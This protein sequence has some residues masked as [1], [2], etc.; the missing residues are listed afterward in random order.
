LPRLD[1]TSPDLT[2]F[3]TFILNSR[4]KNRK[5]LIASNF[6][7]PSQLQDLIP[8]SSIE[9]MAVPFLT[10][11]ETV[12]VLRSYKASDSN[13]DEF[14][15]L[16]H[17]ISHGHPTITSAISKFLRSANWKINSEELTRLFKDDY[18]LDLT[19]ET[20]LNVV[21]TI[22]DSETRELLYRL[23]IIRK[24]FTNAQVNLVAQI[25]PPITSPMEKFNSIIGLWVQ[26]AS[27]EKYELSPLIERLKGENLN[28]IVKRRIN[29]SLGLEILSKKKLNQFE[30]QQTIRYFIEGGAV[31]Q[32][33]F[34]LI[35]ALNDALKTPEIF[36]DWG[37]SLYWTYEELPKDMDVSTKIYIRMLHLML[38]IK[39]EGKYSDRIIFIRN[40]LDK[41][42]L[43]ADPSTVNYAYAS[44]FLSTL[45][46]KDDSS[47]S[48]KHF[49][50]GVQFF[51]S[52]VQSPLKGELEKKFNPEQLIWVSTRAINTEQQVNEWFEAFEAL[53]PDRRAKALEL[54]E[55]R[56]GATFITENLINAEEKKESSS[57]DWNKLLSVFE[58]IKIRA[59]EFGI[60]LLLARAFK[61]IIYIH[62][63]KLDDISKANEIGDAALKIFPED[64]RAARFLISD[65]VG[66][67]LFYKG[68]SEEAKKYVAEAIAMEV[69]DFYTDKLDTFLVMSQLLGDKDKV[70]AHHYIQKA[71]EFVK[72]EFVF[73]DTQRVKVRAEFAISLAFLDR[74]DDAI[75]QMEI[76]YDTIF[77][78]GSDLPD[79]KILT[80]R[81]LHVINYWDSIH[82]RKKQPDD[83]DGEPYE[84]PYRGYFF[85]GYTDDYV[86]KNWMDERPFIGT[87]ALL[88]CFE[89]MGDIAMAKKW[90]LS[91][92]A[93]NK[94][95]TN[96]AFGHIVQLAVPYFVLDDKYDEAVECQV[97]VLKQY[98]TIGE[99]L[100]NIQNERLKKAFQNAPIPR[101]TVDEYDWHII[102]AVIIPTTLRLLRLR[103][104]KHPDTNRLLQNAIA[105]AERWKTIFTHQDSIEKIIEMLK[106]FENNRT[107]GRVLAADLQSYTGSSIDPVKTVGFLIASI[108]TETQ[109]SF[110][111]QAA[112]I[113]SLDETVK[114]IS[115]GSYKF[116]LLPF[117]EAF[118]FSRINEQPGDITNVSFWTQ[119][120]IPYYQNAAEDKKTRMMFRILGNHVKGITVT[121]EL[122]NWIDS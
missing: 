25:D 102:S 79:F 68:K 117:L 58:S 86:E 119:K 35:V 10:E 37:F 26:R 111:L 87:Q 19:E 8:E 72:D 96:N 99:T 42:L 83:I 73:S 18:S 112:L 53:S 22:E 34:V 76:G 30:A 107:D 63:A 67:Q 64:E 31:N 32:A 120:S 16:V 9:Y 4:E 43:S 93:I 78:K 95:M 109:Q 17:A 98:N 65:I 47:K 75:Y 14:K 106:D 55:V 27:D 45:Y 90:A 92:V 15:S 21:K 69:D 13:C 12:E 57:Q 2:R 5:L 116:L 70:S 84:A 80:L 28:S 85:R 74:I 6:N 88:F 33:G 61:S 50:S 23:N 36:F 52:S 59:R 103:I 110:Y 104:E 118:W 48:L 66:R 40:D 81:Y 115:T 41:V 105:A 3:A 101:T 114:K 89:H 113:K 20:Y 38:F 77:S 91:S 82:H 108:N 122:E 56:M 51:E 29:F 100:K 46:S 97:T 121:S 54:D 7:L 71:L 1:K 44:L 39:R 11:D 49:I 94:A 24:A 60:K 62:S